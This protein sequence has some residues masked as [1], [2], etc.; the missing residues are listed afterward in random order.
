MAKG[1]T[2]IPKPCG[3]MSCRRIVF[4]Q[5]GAVRLKSRTNVEKEMRQGLEVV[6]GWKQHLFKN[7]T[8]TTQRELRDKGRMTWTPFLLRSAALGQP[9]ALQPSQKSSEV[10]RANVW[11][12]T[13]SELAELVHTHCAESS[14]D[15]K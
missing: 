4:I 2:R 1:R 9:A 8:L 12:Q 6:L 11:E 7:T 15:C 5:A 14:G 3:G 13:L 10:A